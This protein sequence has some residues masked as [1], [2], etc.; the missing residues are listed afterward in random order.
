MDNV[1]KV[2]KRN[3]RFFWEA[4]N[5]EGTRQGTENFHGYYTTEDV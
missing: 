1:L 2:Q 3:S 4:G 5:F